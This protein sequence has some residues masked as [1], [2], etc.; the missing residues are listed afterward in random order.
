MAVVNVARPTLLHFPATRG[1]GT[2]VIVAPCGADRMLMMSYEGV[3]IAKKLN[4][5]GVDAFVLKYRLKYVDPDGK[6]PDLGGP[7]AGQNIG[8][9]L[10]NRPIRP[11]CK[12]L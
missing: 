1:V 12:T 9:L 7:Q 11:D 2:A 5:A 6:V 3:D 10:T 4:D 8:E